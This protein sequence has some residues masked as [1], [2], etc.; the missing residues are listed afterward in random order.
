MTAGPPLRTRIFH[1]SLFVAVV[2]FILGIGIYPL[3]TQL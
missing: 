3:L 1:L 2:L